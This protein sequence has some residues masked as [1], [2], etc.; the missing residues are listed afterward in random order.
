[1]TVRAV[2]IAQLF[3]PTMVSQNVHMHH[4]KCHFYDLEKPE[5]FGILNLILWDS[6]P[7]LFKILKT[8][9]V[10]DILKYLLSVLE[11]NLMELLNVMSME[12]H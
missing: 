10:P 5:T 8:Q 7:D 9:T 3:P 4:Q 1:M 12:P 11:S 2:L 6:R